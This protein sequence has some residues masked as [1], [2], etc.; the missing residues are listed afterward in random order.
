MANETMLTDQNFDQE[1]K[2]AKGLVLV[3]FYADWCMPCRMLTPIV[4]QLAE[5]YAGKVTIGK[6]DVD[7]NFNTA[8]QFSVSGIPT[9]ILFKDGQM[10]ERLVGLQPIDA[11]KN[12]LEKHLAPAKA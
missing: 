7:K 10:K 9:L 5:E 1:V 12:V 6:L 11:L 8:A 3:D 4:H 2:K